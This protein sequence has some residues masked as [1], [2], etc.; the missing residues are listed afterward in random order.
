MDP[1]SSLLVECRLQN[2]SG[3]YRAGRH[4]NPDPE[5]TGSTTPLTSTDL[6]LLQVSEVHAA[7]QVCSQAK[8]D[9]ALSELQ[10]EKDE[11]IVEVRKKDP[12]GTREIQSCF[13]NF[14]K[15]PKGE[16]DPFS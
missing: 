9:A 2:G 15:Y 13:N 6:S 7:Y 1:I 11:R 12:V 4:A 16:M 8:S 3:S 14:L 5:N 10:D